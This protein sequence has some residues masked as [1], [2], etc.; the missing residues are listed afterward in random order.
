MCLKTNLFCK[1]NSYSVSEIH[2]YSDFRHLMYLKKKAFGWLT[3]ILLFNFIKISVKH[4]K[5]LQ[6]F[7]GKGKGSSVND[8]SRVLKFL[9][10]PPPVSH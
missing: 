7:I 9:A 2:T 1:P 6:K 4:L 3:L 5:I 10:P 8:I